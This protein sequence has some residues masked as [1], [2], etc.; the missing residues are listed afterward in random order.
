L[1]KAPSGKIGAVHYAA[2]DPELQFL[3]EQYEQL[4]QRLGGLTPE[5]AAA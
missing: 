5:R 3:T 4:S 2:G 1:N